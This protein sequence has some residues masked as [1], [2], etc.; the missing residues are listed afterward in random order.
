M[1]YKC[2]IQLAEIIIGSIFGQPK[3]KTPSAPALLPFSC[4]FR[5]T[6]LRPF[7]G[8][9]LFEQKSLLNR[10]PTTY[11]LVVYNGIYGPLG[12]GSR[13][14]GARIFMR[15]EVGL[16]RSWIRKLRN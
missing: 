16:E 7:N 13:I 12:K 15:M 6:L 2:F 14:L 5:E 10:R 8:C 4:L 3:K 1:S 11:M 9:F